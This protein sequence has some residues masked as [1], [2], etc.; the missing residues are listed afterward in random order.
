MWDHWRRFRRT[1]RARA[2]SNAP[3]G[4]T[5]IYRCNHHLFQPFVSSYGMP[6]RTDSVIRVHGFGG[7][8]LRSGEDLR[9][10]RNHQGK[11]HGG[12]LGRLPLHRGGAAGGI[13]GREQLGLRRDIHAQITAVQIRESRRGRYGASFAEMR[14]RRWSGEFCIDTHFAWFSVSTVANVAHHAQEQT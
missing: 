7:E 8:A 12:R 11:R 6:R 5:L 4:V 2:L 10:L 13:V 1:G 3:V 14:R 9:R